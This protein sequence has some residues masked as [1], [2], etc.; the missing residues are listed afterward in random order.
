MKRMSVLTTQMLDILRN[1]RVTR[2][3]AQDVQ[4]VVTPI[5]IEVG[6]SLPFLFQSIV[7]ANLRFCMPV[8]GLTREGERFDAGGKSEVDDTVE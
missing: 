8:N 7:L 3:L 5:C 1:K 6:Y 4:C 2:Y